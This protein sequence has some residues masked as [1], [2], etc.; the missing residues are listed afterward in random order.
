MIANALCR[1]VSSALHSCERPKPS[2][3]ATERPIASRAPL[4]PPSMLPYSS[5]CSPA[6]SACQLLMSSR[7][8]AMP[9]R[10]ASTL[11]SERLDTCDAQPTNSE[12]RRCGD[13]LI[14]SCTAS[15]AAV[16]MLASACVVYP[17]STSSGRTP[18]QLSGRVTGIS[19]MSATSTSDAMLALGG[20]PVAT[21]PPP[22]LPP[23]APPPRS[24]CVMVSNRPSTAHT[25]S[26]TCDTPARSK[27]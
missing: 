10:T 2:R 9:S 15:S 16:R 4:L 25:C 13:E 11:S 14:M 17:C 26:H 21:A 6:R 1:T 20:G 18:F 7:S 8:K 22:P 27:G 3:R 5:C 19:R 24:G 12:F 23:P